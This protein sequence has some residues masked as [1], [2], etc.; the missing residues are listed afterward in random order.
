MPTAADGRVGVYARVSSY[1]RRQD[2][3]WQ[4]ARPTDW[5]ASN[6]HAIAEVL[7]EVGSGL[8]GKRPNLRRILSDTA[9]TVVV[10]EHWD[11][12]VRSGAAK[13]TDPEPVVV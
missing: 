4:V 13:A 8:N 12:L 9:A 7:T 3:D 6:G 10:V 2:L 1:D 11:R 5:T